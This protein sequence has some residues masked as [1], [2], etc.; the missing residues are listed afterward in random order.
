MKRYYLS[1]ILSLMR[2]T[3]VPLRV[4]AHV[5]SSCLL[6][7]SLNV[8]ADPFAV[9][10]GGVSF[11]S[12]DNRGQLFPN[13][14]KF[15]CR[16][17]GCADRHLDAWAIRALENR[18]FQNIE[19]SRELISTN[20][21]E[22]VIATPMITGESVVETM[23]TTDDQ[24][25]FIYTFR[26]FASLLFY[27][28]STGRVIAAVPTIVQ[29]TDVTAA[30]LP[31]RGIEKRFEAMLDPRGGATTLF[32]S[33]FSKAVTVN[34]SNFSSKYI[35]VQHAVIDDEVRAQIDSQTTS[36]WADLTSR[37][38]ESQLAANTG[39]PIVPRIPADQITGELVATFSN[40]AMKIQ[41]PDAIP[42]NFKLRIRNTRLVEK[43]KL[44]QK[45]MCHAV[46]I[47]LGLDGPFESILDAPLVRT[48]ESCGV[49]AAEKEV[50]SLYYFEQSIM[51]LISQAAEQLRE[52]PDPEFFKRAAPK[53]R[54]LRSDFRNAW[55]EVLKPA[56]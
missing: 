45:T 18:E 41:L 34:P 17:G 8:S 14:A 47:S 42:F 15:L 24:T 21:I 49:I 36:R 32:V 54:E 10:W 43:I 50:D 40:G 31:E 9:Y 19:I 3:R 38:L 52:D 20:Q 13:T 48:K 44:K 5:I 39:A 11:P 46:A 22:G 33:L 1:T 26:I 25:N 37:H 53:N 30:K 29:L 16:A 6:A 35:A 7:L 2:R 23:D 51:S 56:F 28:F 55:A 4:T 27:E 12:W